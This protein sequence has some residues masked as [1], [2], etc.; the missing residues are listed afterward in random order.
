MYEFNINALGLVGFDNK[1]K[2]DAN[3]TM[4][5]LFE[6]NIEPKMITGD[7]IFIGIETAVR[8]GIIKSNEPVILLE[9]KKQL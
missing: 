5:K 9:G 7:N 1:L 4:N 8:S 2:T 6:S 3:E